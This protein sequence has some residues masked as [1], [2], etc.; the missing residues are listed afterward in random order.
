MP[1]S[2]YICTKGGIDRAP[3]GLYAN[4]KMNQFFGRSVVEHQKESKK[5]QKKNQQKLNEWRKPVT[6]SKP[7]NRRI[8]SVKNIS[9]AIAKVLG[10]HET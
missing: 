10:K 4:L 2:V 7:T 5:D 8:F 1:D 9:S 3:R 6:K